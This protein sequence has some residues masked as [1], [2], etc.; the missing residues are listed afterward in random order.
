MWVIECASGTRLVF[1]AAAVFGIKRNARWQD[2]DR[3]AIEADVS[4]GVE[5][6]WTAYAPVR[7]PT[8]KPMGTSGERRR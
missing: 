4:G 5:E 3:V 1:E 8:V 2:L 6:A 7:V